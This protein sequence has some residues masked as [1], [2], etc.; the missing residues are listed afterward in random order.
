MNYVKRIVGVPGDTIEMRDKSLFRNNN[1]V[2][3]TYVGKVDGSRD[4]AHPDMK[5]Q[6]RHSVTPWR[7][8]YSPTR[9]NWGPIVVP[10]ESYFVLGD[11]REISEDSRYWGFVTRDGIRGRPWLV[12][13][14]SE[15]KVDQSIRRSSKVRW[16]R[17]GMVIR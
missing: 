12:Y 16:N 1:P 5:W 13:Y 11:N 6:S 9:D 10:N 17:I 2:L 15:P 14:S 8:E 7:P 4:A 3:E